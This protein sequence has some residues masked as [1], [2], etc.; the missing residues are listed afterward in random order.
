MDLISKFYDYANNGIEG[1]RNLTGWRRWRYL[2]AN[3]KSLDEQI[4]S[5]ISNNLMHKKL[6]FML[7]TATPCIRPVFVFAPTKAPVMAP[8]V[9]PT[10]YQ[11]WNSSKTHTIAL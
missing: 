3:A 4:V 8:N 1:T 2:V 9:A 5:E 7:P 11:F 10:A 6:P